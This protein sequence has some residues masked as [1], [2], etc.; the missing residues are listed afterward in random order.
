MLLPSIVKFANGNE[1]AIKTY[2]KFRDYYFNYMEEVEG[3]KYG[4][5]DHSV[6]LSEK[7]KAMNACLLS[8]IERV[9]GAKRGDMSI[10]MYAMNPQVRFAYDVVISQMIDAILPETIEKQ[11][12]IWAEVKTVGYGENA[13][14]TV[15]PNSIYTVSESSNAKRFSFNKK[16]S[17]IDVTLGAVN[18]QITVSAEMYKVLAGVESLARFVRKAVISMETQMGADA[19]RALATLVANANF[20]SALKFAGYDVDKLIGLC[21][22]VQAYNGGA[23]P[24]IVGTKRAIYKMLPDASKGYRMITD[25]Q[26]PEINVIR[27]FF[28]WDI[29]ELDQ[30][31]TGKDDYSMLLDD[32]KLYVISAGSDKLIKGVIE[33]GATSYTDAP[34]DNADLS[35]RTTLNKRYSFDAISNSV[36]GL[37][38]LA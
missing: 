10:E 5:Y 32:T 17:A 29:V 33:G 1:D 16:E 38:D 4:A 23:K 13:H 9:S 25:A 34:Y 15:E 12:G 20:P 3:K 18:H 14:F 37:V 26:N 36:M 22:K 7:E 11:A 27:G 30:V 21:Q 19:Y 6:S 31:A 2:E 28:D 8:E 24:S 35:Q